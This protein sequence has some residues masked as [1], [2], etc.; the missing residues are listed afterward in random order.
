MFL[1]TK[2]GARN[3]GMDE[4]G[5]ASLK[6][7]KLEKCKKLKLPAG[8]VKKLRAKGVEVKGK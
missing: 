7:L 1:L 6:E 3:D 4:I 8:L 5:L 2:V